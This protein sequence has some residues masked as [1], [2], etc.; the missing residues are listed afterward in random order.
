LIKAALSRI[1]AGAW[2]R[3]LIILAGT[4]IALALLASGI[5]WGSLAKSLQSVD[6]VWLV[7]AALSVPLTVGLK[8]A[9]WREIL[10]IQLEFWPL[11]R[12]VAIGQL[13]NA[14]VPAR[15]GD[16]TRAYWLG[17]EAAESK[18]MLLAG[19]AAEKAVDLVM[20][21]AMLVAVLPTFA[22]PAWGGGLSLIAGPVGWAAL[23]LAVHARGRL[24][25][26]L[27]WVPERFRA[28]VSAL[29][30]AALDGL[31]VLDDPRRMAGVIALSFAVWALS[32][33]T[34]YLLFEAFGL[35]LANPVNAA[36]AVLVTTLLGMVPPTTPGKVGVFHA[37]AAGTLIALG[38][39]EAPA[40][41]YAVTLHALV[42]GTQITLGLWA[43]WSRRGA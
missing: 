35:K 23:W 26:W 29:W 20:T 9:R 19:I 7:L 8:A 25:G 1:G 11:L 38:V 13:I 41:A 27:K 36:V 21:A 10:P 2:L 22:D 33:A 39:K 14:S 18:A 32:A 34:N 15:L 43:L 16:F 4:L 37:L 24:G 42:I 17:E 3:A 30:D 6:P 12:A 31:A 40:L 5:D 28:R